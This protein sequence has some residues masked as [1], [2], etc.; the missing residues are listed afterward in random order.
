MRV[1]LDFKSKMEIDEVDGLTE[2]IIAKNGDEFYRILM[3][4]PRYV[5]S[6]R[7]FIYEYTETETHEAL[8]LILWMA[9]MRKTEQIELA[10]RFLQIELTRFNVVTI[11]DRKN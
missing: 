9:G 8:H 1:H 2:I 10:T 3:I 4:L 11:D 7:R 5:W 6:E